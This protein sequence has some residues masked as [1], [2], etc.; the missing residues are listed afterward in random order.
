M[1]AKWTKKIGFIAGDSTK[2]GGQYCMLAM[3]DGMV[4]ARGCTKEQMASK[5]TESD[6]IPMPWDWWQQMCAFLRAQTN[7][8]P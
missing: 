4:M 1:E 8:T 6:M 3:S 7:S 5:L 2:L